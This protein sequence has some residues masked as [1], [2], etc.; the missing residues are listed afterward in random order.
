MIAGKDHWSLPGRFLDDPGFHPDTRSGK[1]NRG[2]ETSNP[3]RG[4]ARAGNQRG[5]NGK[6]AA[7][8]E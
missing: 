7:Q 1:D 6:G 5:R 4:P 2:P 8:H 3:V